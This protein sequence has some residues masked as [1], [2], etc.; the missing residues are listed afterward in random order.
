[1][2]VGRSTRWLLLVSLTCQCCWGCSA[3]TGP[4]DRFLR[5][6]RGDRQVSVTRV[7]STAIATP[8]VI[9]DPASLEY[10]TSALRAAEPDGY[11]RRKGVRLDI[12]DDC[13]SFQ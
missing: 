2:R 4:H 13:E 9:E 6:L 11:G 12:I 1:M 5:L 10:L 7:E 3:V 8:F